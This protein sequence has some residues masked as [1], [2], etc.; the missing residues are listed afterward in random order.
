M[1]STQPS[2]NYII[3]AICKYV[4][5]NLINKILG[6]LDAGFDLTG[7]G[8]RYYRRL[9]SAFLSHTAIAVRQIGNQNQL[10]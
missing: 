6:L 2:L 9:D 1:V 3:L 4:C 7:K 8:S 10:S 5:Q